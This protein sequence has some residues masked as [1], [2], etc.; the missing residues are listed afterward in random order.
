MT[1]RLSDVEAPSK[2]PQSQAQQ[3]PG[4]ALAAPDMGQQVRALTLIPEDRVHLDKPIVYHHTLW[5]IICSSI[6][7]LN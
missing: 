1:R 3:D 7:D 6:L 4:L 5:I 2:S